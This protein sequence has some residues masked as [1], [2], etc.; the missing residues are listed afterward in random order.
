MLEIKAVKDGDYIKIDFIGNRFLYNMIRA[1]V[2]TLLVIE[3]NNLSPEVMK[4]ILESK[5]KT[6]AGSTISPD[7]LTLIDVIYND[8]NGEKK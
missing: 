3:K 7:G 8:I 5:D 2:G 4:E 1:I 6:K